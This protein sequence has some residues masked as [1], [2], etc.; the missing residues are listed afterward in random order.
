MDAPRHCPGNAMREARDR[1]VE[2]VQ[3]IREVMRRG[4]AV[5]RGAQGQDYLFDVA[6]LK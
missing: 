5:N 3:A 2:V 1:D 6:R 4:L